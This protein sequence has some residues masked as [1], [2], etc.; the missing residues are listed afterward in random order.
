MF[1]SETRRDVAI[2][3]EMGTVMVTIRKLSA[4]SLDL[5]AE[6]RQ[7]VIARTS[8][9]FGPEWMKAFRDESA[10][11]EEEEKR[12]PTPEEE[13]EAI[14]AAYDRDYVLLQ[15][16]VRWSNA[17]K[18]YSKEAIEDLDEETATKLYREIIDLSKPT[19]E[20]K[21]SAEGKFFG[22]STSS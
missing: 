2:E 12:K 20:A 11:R 15:G 9:N 16:I 18:E 10:A 17:S 6:Q 4:R 14:Y 7:V 5:A 8:K 21:E 3:A 22:V 1:A 13:R 19:R